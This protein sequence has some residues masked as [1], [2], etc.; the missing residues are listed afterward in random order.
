MSNTALE[1]IN[2]IRKRIL[3]HGRNEYKWEEMNPVDDIVVVLQA[4][5]ENYNNDNSSRC[6]ITN[7]PDTGPYVQVEFFNGG[8]TKCASSG[9][10][11][12]RITDRVVQKLQRKRFIEGKL[13]PG[14]ISTSEFIITKEGKEFFWTKLEEIEN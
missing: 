14:Y 10:Y 6:I 2:Y 8:Y 13:E 3:H 5:F 4:V 11:Y 9:F 12:I 1:K 7:R